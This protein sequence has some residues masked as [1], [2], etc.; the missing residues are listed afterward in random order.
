MASRTPEQAQALRTA[1]RAWIRTRDAHCKA[2]ASSGGT[3]DR[4][5]GPLCHLDATIKRTAELEAME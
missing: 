5:N 2:K 4:L 1:Q 3:I